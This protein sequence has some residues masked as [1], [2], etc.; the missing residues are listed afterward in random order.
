VIKVEYEGK[1]KAF[2]DV[3][4]Y[5]SDYIDEFGDQLEVDYFQVKYHVSH[6]GAFTFKDL[7]DP[8]FINASRYSI[9]QR[10]YD[11]QQ[12][13]A[14]NGI[15]RRFIIVSPWVIH[16]DD[17][18]S[19]LVS[20]RG[21][22]LLLNKLFDGKPRSKMGRIRNEIKK[23]LNITSDMDLNIFLR[24]LRIW[25]GF[26]GIDRLLQEINQTFYSVGLKP[27]EVN[28]IT[29]PY[30]SLL[31]ELHMRG[32]TEFSRDELLEWLVREN[33]YEGMLQDKP[34]VQIGIRSFHRRAEYMEDETEKML[35]L[36]PYFSGR[37]ILD[38]KFWDTEFFSKIGDFLQELNTSDDYHLHL[39]TH[40]S[41]AFSAGYHLDNKSGVNISPVQRGR[42][43]V[44]WDPLK[45]NSKQ[46]TNYC[47][48]IIE[49]TVIDLTGSDCALA[50]NIT[51]DITDDVSYFLKESDTRIKKLISLKLTGNTGSNT[52]QDGMHAWN[53]AEQISQELKRRRS[54]DER[55]ATL[56]IFYSGPVSLMF[57]IGQLSR[58]FGRCS[59]YEYQFEI[60]GTYVKGIT[61]PQY[62]TNYPGVS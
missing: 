54:P 32:I 1:T 60:Q 48:C 40:F 39:D 13:F 35:C 12:K 36:I 49:E 20:N 50:I 37:E 21:N 16:P 28:K 24:T 15:G 6:N 11:A 18:L 8:D 29:N 43:K 10:A 30:L 62:K 2:D 3:I 47:S 14:P 25:A 26:Q 56:H 27:V 52:I 4:V 9:L 59:I 61:L 45:R 33:L 34:A 17:E 58:S 44:I 19:L 22:E 41:I 23:H 38:E 5:Y 7:M 31:H 46:L 57:F 55:R 51:H 53:L 42:G